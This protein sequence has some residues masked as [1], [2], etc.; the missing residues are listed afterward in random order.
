M[1]GRDGVEPVTD[2]YWNETCPVIL[3]Q[4]AVWEDNET[5]RNALA[6]LASRVFGPSVTADLMMYAGID[7]GIISETRNKLVQEGHE[8]VAIN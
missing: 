3:E 7:H 5:V 6:D 4:F 1:R 2:E 8:E